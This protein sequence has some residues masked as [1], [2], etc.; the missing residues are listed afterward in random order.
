[1]VNIF[2][3]FFQWQYFAPVQQGMPKNCSVDLAKVINYI[4]NVLVNGTVEEQYELKASFGLG[5]LEHND[6]F[7]A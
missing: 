5:A 6:D 2:L 4:D 1:M 7:G 3:T